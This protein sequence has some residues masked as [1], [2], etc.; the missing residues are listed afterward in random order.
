MCWNTNQW[1]QLLYLQMNKVTNALI[2]L[3]LA[4]E[5]AIMWCKFCMI[6]DICRCSHC[7]PGC[8]HI[9]DR[10]Q[11]LMLMGIVVFKVILPLRNKVLLNYPRAFSVS[12]SG[13]NKG[14]FWS[15]SP[16]PPLFYKWIRVCAFCACAL[17]RT[18]WW[19]RFHAIPL[20][21]SWWQ[22]LAKKKNNELAQ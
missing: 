22:Y 14:T 16:P 17:R 11:L 6:Q 15:F 3:S 19:Q 12:L 9:S 7:P 10:Q 13:N 4:Q 8:D 5:S 2:M 20:M 1:T 18:P 21:D